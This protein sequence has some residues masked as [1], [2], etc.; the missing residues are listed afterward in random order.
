MG[1]HSHGAR[2]AVG[3]LFFPSGL[4]QT[5]RARAPVTDAPNI[6][7]SACPFPDFNALFVSTVEFVCG[8][9]LV[10]GALNAARV[11]DARVRYDHGDCNERDSKHRGI[12][13]GCLACGI[14]IPAGATLPGDSHLA[15]LLGAGMAQC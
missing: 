12:V 3:L 8:V 7:R 13:S 1:R 10:I 14:F 4:G 11:C 9:L 15:F 2:I 5:F 6:D